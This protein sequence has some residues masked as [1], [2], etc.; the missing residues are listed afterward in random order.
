MT[1]PRY[2][3]EKCELF[4][5]GFGQTFS[6]LPVLLW[7]AKQA[8]LRWWLRYE[9]VI[10]IVIWVK[11]RPIRP[12]T[13]ITC[14]RGSCCPCLCQTWLT[15][16]SGKQLWL[17]VTS[18][19]IK[20]I[21]PFYFYMIDNVQN[22]SRL[23]GDNN[24]HRQQI[25]RNPNLHIYK[26]LWIVLVE[27]YILYV[28]IVSKFFYENVMNFCAALWNIAHTS[29]SME[30]FGNKACYVHSGLIYRKSQFW[31]IHNW[32]WLTLFWIQAYTI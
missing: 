6:P 19:F 20:Y 13:C 25:K 26:F 15:S 23:I 29:F 8:K 22:T 18:H 28:W 9:W 27:F 3:V 1:L 31:Q 10:F 24:N 11:L 5:R 7:H 16:L 2:W 14:I 12:H 32:L 17:H 30:R 21:H 4:I